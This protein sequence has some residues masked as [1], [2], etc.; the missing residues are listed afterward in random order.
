MSG[1]DGNFT[2]SWN[3]NNWSFLFS[4]LLSWQNSSGWWWVVERLAHCFGFNFDFI[5]NCFIFLLYCLSFYPL[6]P[7]LPTSSMFVLFFFSWHPFYLK[8]PFLSSANQSLISPNCHLM[9]AHLLVSLWMVPGWL[10]ATF[11][12]IVF[13]CILHLCRSCHPFF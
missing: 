3:P 10:A 2:W 12:L 5:P 4:L 11:P 9:P 8:V 7:R 1:P 13:F 6:N